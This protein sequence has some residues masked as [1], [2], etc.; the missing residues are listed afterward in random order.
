MIKIPKWVNVKNYRT[1][2]STKK[3]GKLKRQKK[4]KLKV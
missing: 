1:M 2:T 3:N 4:D